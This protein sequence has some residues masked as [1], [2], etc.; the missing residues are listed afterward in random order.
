M[1]VKVDSSRLEF[2]EAIGIGH[3]D[4]KS[5]LQSDVLNLRNEELSQVS[6]VNFCAIVELT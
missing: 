1:A 6:L 5:F 2:V 4:T 3:L